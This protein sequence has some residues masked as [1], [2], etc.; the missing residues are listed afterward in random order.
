MARS[1]AT[2]ETAPET[3]QDMLALLETS[4]VVGCVVL[5]ANG[6][7][8]RANALFR[9]W[10]EESAGCAKIPR[11]LVAMLPRPDDVRTL[12][13]ALEAGGAR[14]IAIELK[15]GAGAHLPL[16]GDLIPIVRRGQP[17]LLAGVFR[18]AHADKKLKD[19][20]ERSARL[21]ALGSLTSGVAHDFNNLLTILVGNLAL[22]AEELRGEPRQFEKLKSARD[23]ARRGS[24]LIKQLLSFARQ[25]P[26]ESR[27]IN[28]ANVIARIAPLIQRALG[29][30]I[31]LE[32]ALDEQGDPIQGNSGQLESVIVNLAVNAR[33]A[34]EGSGRVRI[35]V[36]S[37][38]AELT[39]EV[40]DDGVGIPAEIADRVFEPFFT[41]KA[42]GKGSGLGLSMVRLYAEQ[43]GGTAELSSRP[44]AGTSVRLKF[45]MSAGSVDESAAMTMPV[46][47]LPSGKEHIVVVAS[48]DSVSVMTTQILSV[49]GYRCEVAGTPERAREL[50]RASLPDLVIID[51]FDIASIVAAQQSI[52]GNASRFLRLV[53]IDAGRAKPDCPT[54]QK[55]FSIPDLAVSV[56]SALDDT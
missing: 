31:A 41:T 24:E 27:S 18:A 6:E 16:V 4:S 55:P 38:G 13:R 46:A 52:H 34:I 29:S 11:R 39:V 45:P 2:A 5:A 51:S 53:A 36:S 32:L 20:M 9:R 33:D 23:A 26:V 22:V 40:S 43:F 10:L 44:G 49:L 56:R 50:F 8:R 30:R 25:E 47:S 3:A 37:A 7:I 54:L 17:P 14:E 35:A 21:E 48:D 15:A 28:P 12:E 42:D 1:G 19:G